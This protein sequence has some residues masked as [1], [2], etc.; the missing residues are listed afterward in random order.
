MKDRIIYEIPGYKVG[1]CFAERYPDRPLRQMNAAYGI[2]PG[3]AVEGVHYR[4]LQK[5]RATKKE[6]IRL[7]KKWQ[8][9]LGYN[10]DGAWSDNTI[11]GRKAPRTEESKRRISE[12]LMGHEVSKETRAKISKKT[13]KYF[14]DNP[15][16]KEHF[17]RLY[18]KPVLVEHKEYISLGD[19]CR[20]TGITRAALRY[21]IQKGWPGHKFLPKGD[22]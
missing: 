12:S 21:R 13:S 5:V 7:E 2:R 20:A 3:E 9:E 18:G 8:I 6:V 19:A 1:E 17:K 14:K 10:T 11:A 15:W 4:I 16:I 22:T